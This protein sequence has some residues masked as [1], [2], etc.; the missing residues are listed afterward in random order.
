MMAKHV[1]RV[2]RATMWKRPKEEGKDKDG[3]NQRD[4][5]E[6]TARENHLG[7]QKVLHGNAVHGPTYERQ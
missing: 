4:G 1:F 6:C 2:C 7:G 3:A 5:E